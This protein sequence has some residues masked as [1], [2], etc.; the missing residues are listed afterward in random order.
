MITLIIEGTQHIIVLRAILF[1]E[2]LAKFENMFYNRYRGFNDSYYAVKDEKAD[3]LKM[4]W[5]RLQKSERRLI[6]IEA[7]F[8]NGETAI[9]LSPM[10]QY[11]TGQTLTISGLEHLD[12]HTEIHFGNIYWSRAIVKKGV[13]D[14]HTK[15][16]SVEVPDSF[17]AYPNKNGGLI[18]IYQTEEKGGKTID[19]IRVPILSRDKPEDYILPDGTNTGDVLQN[20]VNHYL[21]LH[22]Y[23]V[24]PT[25]TSQLTN[26]SGFLT[27][28]QDISGKA[29]KA[30]TLAGYGITNAYTKAQVDSAIQTAIGGVEN[31][32]Y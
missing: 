13:Y 18:W 28:H 15:T 12:S 14:A 10:W 9:T 31:G 32:S 7:K 23:A 21:D 27:Q 16:L 30:T 2:L 25:K 24:I 26:D 6:I 19:E 22:G 3:L 29:D 17:F 5:P 8:T 11:D 1:F 4:I 20:A